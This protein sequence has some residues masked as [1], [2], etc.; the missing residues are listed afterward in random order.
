MGIKLE[1]AEGVVDEAVADPFE[2]V[3]ESATQN[4]PEA[5]TR[6][7]AAQKPES[8]GDVFY[9]AKLVPEALRPSFQRMQAAWTKKTQEF[10]EQ[11]KQYAEFE[12]AYGTVDTVRGVLDQLR[13]PQGVMNWVSAVVQQ[14][15]KTPQDLQ[16]WLTQQGVPPAQAAQV[17]QAATPASGTVQQAGVQNPDDPNR[18]LTY[19]E[20]QSILAQQQQAFE[21]QQTTAREDQEVQQALLETKVPENL[22]YFTLAQAK[23]HPEHLGLAERIRRGYADV[24]AAMNQYADTRTSSAA[25][26]QAQAPRGLGGGMPGAE[27]R[28]SAPR[29]W[30]DA[31]REAQRF[32]DNSGGLYS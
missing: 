3:A 26:A 22:Q 16:Q 32:L 15:G 9:D 17:A 27:G 23:L 20:L 30:G 12:K 7:E 29:T 10:A 31:A 11:R 24:Q 1:G 2:G 25:G 5:T 6:Q 13:D 4:D 19:G 21:A 8:E 28:A 14:F 18:P